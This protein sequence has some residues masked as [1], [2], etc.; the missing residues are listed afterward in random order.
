MVQREIAVALLMGEALD[1]QVS[2]HVATCAECAA[3]QSSLRGVTQLLPQLTLPD[4][5]MPLLE[6]DAS[7]LPRLMQRVTN[8]RARQRRSRRLVGA[9]ALALAAAVLAVAGAT[10]GGVF[11]NAEHAILASASANGIVATADITPV[12]DGSELSL[13]IKGVPRGTHC[14]LRVESV[15]SARETLTV[16]TA[17]YY[18]TAT[19]SGHS[20][21][22]PS[23]IARVT[24]SRVGG[25][26]L[27]SIPVA[28]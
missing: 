2:T 10:L 11:S 16:W 28:T 19:T 20:S 4:L 23:D 12:A 3:E 13:S 17:D 15:S 24:V 22:A 21:F 8:E 6:D 1:E 25:P 26:L 14:I 18:G 9:S 5:T 27:L 7:L